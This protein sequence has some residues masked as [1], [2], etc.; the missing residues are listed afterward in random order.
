[1]AKIRKTI[2][3]KTISL[4]RGLGAALVYVIYFLI[5]FSKNSLICNHLEPVILFH[6]SVK[7]Q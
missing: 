4:I 3:Y 7:L 6:F 2:F 5:Y 1:M